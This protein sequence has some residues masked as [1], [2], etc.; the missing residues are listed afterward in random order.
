MQSIRT[1]QLRA[2][3]AYDGSAYTTAKPWHLA[4]GS[5]LNTGAIATEEYVTNAVSA[6]AYTHV[7]AYVF[8]DSSR[9]SETYTETGSEV[10]P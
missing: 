10:A 3:L 4:T 6:G 7:D 9:S 8:V 2:D 1:R 5:T